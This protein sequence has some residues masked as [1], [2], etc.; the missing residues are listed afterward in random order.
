MSTRSG[1]P[2]SGWFSESPQRALVDFLMKE[3]SRYIPFPY[4]NRCD[5]IFVHRWFDNHLFA[6]AC[7]LQYRHTERLFE[8]MHP[9]YAHATVISIKHFLVSRHNKHS[10]RFRLRWS[11]HD[12]NFSEVFLI[13]CFGLAE[14]VAVVPTSYMRSR[15]GD[16]RNIEGVFESDQACPSLLAPFMVH[17]RDLVKFL[18]QIYLHA[19]T[20]ATSD[21]VNPT[22]SATYHNWMPELQCLNEVLPKGSH[23]DKLLSM[24]DLYFACKL[25]KETITL[26]HKGDP[27][28]F[29]LDEHPVEYWR[30]SWC[31]RG[32]YR[33]YIR[34]TLN[35]Q[36]PAKS[37]W[38]FLL[39]EDYHGKEAICLPRNLVPLHLIGQPGHGRLGNNPKWP[40]VEVA[41]EPWAAFIF[42][43][44]SPMHTATAIASIM[45][46]YTHQVEYGLS[47]NLT[48]GDS[49]HESSTPRRTRSGMEDWIVKLLDS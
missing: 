44:R 10:E 24:R 17:H 43:I 13:Q 19:S 14:H 39:L 40:Q 7:N 36:L 25:S 16:V 20:S 9:D 22:F 2:I 6:P 28:H 31:R 3:S 46:N 29:T 27:G 1:T 4:I 8:L 11:K 26:S 23:L 45:R 18:D 34:V 37:P 12:E 42:A 32:D 47:R 15:Y 41:A 35:H 5:A 38:E 49:G 33:G 48:E 30:K 21:L